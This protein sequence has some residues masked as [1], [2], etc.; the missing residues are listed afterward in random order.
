MDVRSPHRRPAA[1]GICT[2]SILLALGILFLMVQPA[3]ATRAGSDPA[4]PYRQ[5]RVAWVDVEAHRGSPAFAGAEIMHIEEGSYV[6]LLGR[7]AELEALSAAGIPFTI[8]IEDLEAHY[9]A[10]AKDWAARGYVDNFGPFHTYSETVAA[11]DE[12]HA[13]YPDITTARIALGTS[14]EGNT[15][16]AM[17]ISDNPTLEEPDEPEVLFDGIHHAREVMTVEMLLSFMVHLGAN[18]GSDP[19][20]TYLVDNRQV[21]FVPIVNPDGYLYNEFTNPNGG[22]MWRKNRRNDLG[23]C[24]GVDLNRNYPYE[25]VGPG[26]STDPCSETY[27]GPA[28]ASEFELQA[29]IAFINDHRFVTQNTYHS[30]AG[31]ILFPWAYT[32]AHTP[33]DAIFRS[34]A[35]EMARES[36]YTIGQPPEILYV[37]NGG[38]MDWSYGEQVTKPKIFCFST[39]IGGS[40]F[41]PDPSE[42]PGLI[43]ENLNSNLFLVRAAGSYP[44]LAGFAISGGNG[45]GRLDP[46]E[47]ADL[48]VT[49]RNHGVIA[50]AEDVVV[51]LS[52]NDAYIELQ[53]AESVLGTIGA[54][55]SVANTADPFVVSADATTPAGHQVMFT[56]EIESSGGQLLRRDLVLRVGL[57]DYLYVQDFEVDAGGWEQDAAHTATTGAFVRIDPNP[58]QFQPGDDTT[59]PPG[60]YA[61]ITG[62]NFDVGNEDVDGGVSATHSPVI[63][64]SGETR[65]RLVMNYFHGQRDQGDDPTGDYFRIQLSNDGGASYPVNLVAIGD[66]TT[67]PEWRELAVDLETVLPLTAA[68]RLRVLASDGP[69]TGDIIEGGIDDVTIV[70]PGSGN[71]P[72]GAPVLVSPPNGA[73]GLPDSPELVVMNAVDPEGDPLT[74]GFR[75][76]ADPLL[77]QL[78]RSVDGVAAGATQT[79]WMVG[80][81]LLAGTYYW[82]AYAADPELRGP[83]MPAAAFTVGPVTAVTDGAAPSRPLLAAPAPNPFAAATTVT[84]QLSRPG[85]VRLDLFDATG[86]HVR[87]LVDGAVEAGL[88]TMAWDGLDT[89]GRAVAPGVYLAQLWADGAV[90][91]KKLVRLK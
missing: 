30:V 76:Y 84:Y 34:M 13:L 37:V 4:D 90:E 69:A 74:Y 68:M 23:S 14:W 27:R 61:W 43:A 12:I 33:D 9:A 17:K 55:Q 77:T 15:I 70:H 81:P 19:E 35:T 3:L 51:R 56:V 66:V 54:G 47:T 62:Q 80:P 85:R 5:V 87:R 58:T 22:G 20:V 91:T 67:T 53:D 46:G 28:A 2:A 24:I 88:H 50:A 18:Y 65:A 71:L 11:M 39:E 60:I 75:V 79:T 36:G 64:L 7:N 25:W 82:R 83:F 52:S 32:T 72:P 44:D 8:E 89:R 29:F 26:S 49:V 78:V 57:P 31:M 59:P 38:S 48:V 42:A 86:R 6:S 41:W 73:G 21:W 63:D 45:N 40:G 1:F 10:R 16:W